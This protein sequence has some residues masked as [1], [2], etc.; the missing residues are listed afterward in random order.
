MNKDTPVFTISDITKSVKELLEGSL[1]PC[2][3]EGE[4]SNWT[5][6]S[7]GHC[8]FSLKD[9][10]SQIRAVIWR[11]QRAGIMFK[12][13]DGMKVHAYGAI[14]VYER[15]GNYQINVFKMQPEGIG[16]LQLAYE[17]LK[18]KL[19]EEGLFDETR[20]KPLPEGITSVGVVTSPTGAALRDI[21]NVLKR[22][23]PATQIIL[24]P[25]RVQG[26]GAA[27][28]IAR[29]I[30]EFNE[31]GMVDI[32]IVGRGGG[33]IED[34]WAFNEEIVARAIAE[35][36]LPVVSAVGHEVD[37][38]IADFVA[39]LRAPTP[40]AAAEL[41]VSDQEEQQENL[42]LLVD[43]F[44]SA[45][46][47]YFT[48]LSERMRSLAKV[49]EYHNPSDTVNQY[50]QRVDELTQRLSLLLQHQ[51]DGKKNLLG[52]LLGKL[53]GLSPLATF[54]RGYSIVRCSDD[55]KVLK[56]VKQVS[57][58]DM[59]EVLLNDGTLTGKIENIK[60]L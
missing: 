33:S 2:W 35:S 34:L 47:Y 22:R 19:S 37:Y 55:K 10:K 57:L 15:G 14:K 21:V 20:K 38:T 1:V 27:E 4:I 31:Y 3:V 59:I 49:L 29:A 30:R 48:S 39:D 36:E 16:A 18:K 43:R 58:S 23:A 6:H 8:Y 40:S 51:V 60:A 54:N 12:P 56:S 11:G 41:V 9:E 17:Q 42:R 5:A 28:E 26:T 7:S 45:A 46:Q 24:N 52:Q 32:L 50:M 44:I 25:A 53:D 13:E